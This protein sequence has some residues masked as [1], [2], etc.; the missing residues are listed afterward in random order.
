LLAE[1]AGKLETGSRKLQ[2]LHPRVFHDGQGKAMPVFVRFM[3]DFLDLTIDE[4]RA[5]H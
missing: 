4:N 2:L 3:P 5:S 1:G